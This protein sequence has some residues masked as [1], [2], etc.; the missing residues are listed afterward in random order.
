MELLMDTW[1]HD[2][3]SILRILF[4]NIVTSTTKQFFI[5]SM[6]QERMDYALCTGSTSLHN[7]SPTLDIA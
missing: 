2:I 3:Q 6:I 5:K 1:L 7:F 4:E